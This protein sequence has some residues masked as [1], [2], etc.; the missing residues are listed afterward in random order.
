[1]RLI[2]KVGAALVLAAGL[3][4]APAAHAIAFEEADAGIYA[5]L[6]KD[7]KATKFAYRF[8]LQAGKWVA[9][10]RGPDGNWGAVKCD[11]DCDIKP[12]A[13]ADLP[14]FI[15]GLDQITPGCM[16]NS[17]LAFCK[18]LYKKDPAVPRFMTVLNTPQGAVVLFMSF[19][20]PM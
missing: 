11:K 6:D 5:V 9:E 18:Y 14:R 17:Q 12:I 13:E 1:M 20:A 15:P 3:L 8:Y 10:Q 7:G 16:R 4:A 19:L 2:K